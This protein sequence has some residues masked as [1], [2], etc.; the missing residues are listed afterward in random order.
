V[1][2]FTEIG[3]SDSAQA[4]DFVRKLTTRVGLVLA[5]ESACFGGPNKVYC[6]PSTDPHHHIY[7]LDAGE[8]ADV[9]ATA[10]E[11]S[12]LPPLLEGTVAEGVDVI[13]RVRTGNL[14]A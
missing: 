6:D 3:A 9:D 14:P 4:H 11:I 13:V 12:R 5:R 7:N 10:I 1:K 8:L 2:K